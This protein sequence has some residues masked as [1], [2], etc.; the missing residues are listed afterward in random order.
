MKKWISTMALGLSVLLAPTNADANEVRLV[1]TDTLPLKQSDAP[2][3]KTIQTLQ[4]GQ[5]VTILDGSVYANGMEGYVD[6]TKLTDVVGANIAVYEPTF[7]MLKVKEDFTINRYGKL[8][9]FGKDTYV[10]RASTYYNTV[11]S[12]AD[13][14]AD[15]QLNVIPPT[16]RTSK[17]TIIVKE[18]AYK[19]AKTVMTLPAHTVVES[20][21]TL[22]GGWRIIRYG[23]TIGFVTAAPMEAVKGTK[24]YVAM[25]GLAL[26]DR[27]HTKEGRIAFFLKQNTE[28]T[29]YPSVNGWSYV[30][31]GS[32][33]GYVQTDLLATTKTTRTV[34]P[35]EGT[36]IHVGAVKSYITK[37]TRHTDDQNRIYFTHT[38][39]QF[40]EQTKSY[41]TATAIQ[42][43]G[44]PTM[45]RTAN[46][47]T[48]EG[49]KAAM[50]LAKKY[51]TTFSADC[52]D[53]APVCHENNGTYTF[54]T[55]EQSVAN[56][57]STNV[58][59]VGERVQFMRDDYVYDAANAKGI[60]AWTFD[61]DTKTNTFTTLGMTF[62]A[63]G[64]ADK[65]DDSWNEYDA[66]QQHIARWYSDPTYL[67]P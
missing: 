52:A 37:T 14:V 19:S 59:V 15:D 2:D 26:R 49:V 51:R 63:G 48:M 56:L 24:A 6:L 62:V 17:S 58:K 54:K 1:N 41:V 39:K 16:M 36:P 38:L 64:N 21:G 31:A 65:H 61:F 46:A 53:G 11:I 34:T 5:P 29:A 67:L 55:N 66:F 23:D 4:K 27:P 45:Y 35:R 50:M 22:P 32:L 7:Q 60:Y 20:Y 40:D 12:H 42:Y 43:A 25:E 8:R 44:E 18:G 9:E 33:G 3:A 57:A 30:Q 28:V 10:Y 47:V 13:D